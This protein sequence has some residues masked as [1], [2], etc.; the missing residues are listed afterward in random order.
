[1]HKYWLVVAVFYVVVFT[2]TNKKMKT[3]CERRIY[4]I[5][6]LQSVNRIAL[7]FIHV[8]TK[9]HFK[10]ATRYRCSKRIVTVSDSIPVFGSPY[11][12]TPLLLTST[13]FIVVY[14]KIRESIKGLSFHFSL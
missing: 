2:Y 5:A 13:P 3:V 6:S 8:L 7:S 10:S 14:N 9:H 12:T 1:M 4:I 11:R